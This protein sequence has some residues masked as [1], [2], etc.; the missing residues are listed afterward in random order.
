MGP[1]GNGSRRRVAANSG[2][3]IVSN[4]VQG[5]ASPCERTAA[6]R[7][8]LV[9]DDH[10]SIRELLA[11]WARNHGYE[12]GTAAD[13]A[14][15]LAALERQPF[16]L[17]ISDVRMPGLTGIELL[18]RLPSA[19]SGAAFVFITGFGTVQ[20][21]VQALQAGALDY[22]T[23][24][25][26]VEELFTRIES[27]LLERGLTALESPAA[28]GPVATLVPGAARF[29]RAASPAP[30]AIGPRP[31]FALQSS[32][33]LVGAPENLRKLYGLLDQVAPSRCTV[34]ISG[35]SG[36]GKELVATELHQ[37]SNRAGKPFVRVNCPAIPREL[38]ESE[39][40]GHEKGAFTGAARRKEGKFFFAN[41][42]TILLDEISETSLAFQSKLL[43]V[44]QE[45]EYERV[46]GND[47]IRL[48]VR[49]IATSNRNMSEMVAKGKFREDLFYRLNVVPIEIQPLGERRDDVPFLV[50]Y[51]VRRFCDENGRP[52]FVVSPPA[53]NALVDRPWAGNVRQL[54]NVC[55]RAVVLKR[56]GELLEV[57][58]FFL[59]LEI[60]NATSAAPGPRDSTVN[61]ME[62]D[63]ILRTL[64]ETRAN[65]T[66]AA[67]RLGISVRTLR[68]KLNEYRSLNI[69]V[70][71]VLESAAR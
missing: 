15:A 5:F 14:E 3:A 7:R 28:P 70:D 26:N 52:P 40:F 41:G 19:S 43:R 33:L 12:P 60:D 48:D 17:V 57:P 22:V 55:E 4:E 36:V 35:P 23:K 20:E 49:L 1:R 53:M 38:Q 71:G 21:A 25:F 65:R 34:F 32:G 61:G 50:E 68:N 6:A 31:L 27:R 8:L 24:P 13:G 44:L 46:G 18:Q 64:R 62:R 66:E 58:D 42:G 11:S 30:L 16:D 47:L 39:L 37:R 45:R 29:D 9:V 10:A 67:R 69:D 2:S 54:Q 63:L 56:S 51:F 59:E